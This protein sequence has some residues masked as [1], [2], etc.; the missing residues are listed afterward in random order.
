MKERGLNPDDSQLSGKDASPNNK[1]EV[2]QSHQEEPLMAENGILQRGGVKAAG[3]G[4]KGQ[5][6]FYPNQ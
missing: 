1:D 3:K 5:V 2:D 4:E 6:T